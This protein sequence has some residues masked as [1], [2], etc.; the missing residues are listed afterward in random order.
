MGDEA[1]VLPLWPASGKLDARQR[2]VECIIDLCHRLLLHA[3]QNVRIQVE[4]D[5]DLAVSKTPASDFGVNTSGEHHRER[6]QSRQIAVAEAIRK[7][8]TKFLQ[9][10]LAYSVNINSLVRIPSELSPA[11]R[12][13][14]T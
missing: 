10:G 4:R 11:C 6:S 13:A 7:D 2:R 9:G 8:S 14:N 1:G 5:A 3:G 12:I